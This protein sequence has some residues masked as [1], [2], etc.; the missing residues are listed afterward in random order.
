MTIKEVAAELQV[1]P[2]TVRHLLQQGKFPGVKRR[3]HWEIPNN[4]QR[5]M[6]QKLLRSFQG[7]PSTEWSTRK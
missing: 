2:W 7:I 3:T 4:Y 6:N 1:S 5:L